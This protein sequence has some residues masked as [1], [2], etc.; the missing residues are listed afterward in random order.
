MLFCGCAVS[1]IC[2]LFSYQWRNKVKQILKTFRAHMAIL[3]IIFTIILNKPTKKIFPFTSFFPFFRKDFSKPKMSPGIFIFVS[4]PPETTSQRERR[5]K[6]RVMSKFIGGVKIS[7]EN[8]SFNFCR[9]E[10]IA[11]LQPTFT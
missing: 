5:W 6:F 7:P 9:H 11:Q 2:I 1:V 8:K 10:S 4:T 3:A